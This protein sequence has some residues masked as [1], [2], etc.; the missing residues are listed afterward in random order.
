MHHYQEPELFSPY[1]L[2]LVMLANQNH[3][4][5]TIH[6]IF[7]K[8]LPSWYLSVHN[9]WHNCWLRNKLEWQLVWYTA[10]S[11]TKSL[12]VKSRPWTSSPHGSPRITQRSITLLR[13]SSVA[14][15]WH[16]YHTTGCRKKLWVF[17]LNNG[18]LDRRDFGF[19]ASSSVQ[20]FAL[21]WSS[22]LPFV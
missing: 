19:T 3:L 1:W 2:Y 4:L 12:Q 14:F 13:I 18:A 5:P 8:S 10:S 16:Q 11:A 22:R 9:D 15:S 6:I 7:Q 17:Q 20:S 21:C